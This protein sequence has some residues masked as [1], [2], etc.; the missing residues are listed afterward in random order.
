LHGPLIILFEQQ[1]ADESDHGS[2]V[3][4]DA[5]HVA[6]PL[7]L[8]IETFEWVGTVNLGAVLGREVYNPEQITALNIVPGLIGVVLLF[9]T[10]IATTLA[11]TRERETGT[12]E[13]LLAMPV[14]GTIAVYSY[15]K[16]LD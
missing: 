15:R 6:A 13:N 11:I 7:D 4:K 12:M 10:L 8:A 9:S 14:T 1:R 5:D 3:G 2:L 16:T